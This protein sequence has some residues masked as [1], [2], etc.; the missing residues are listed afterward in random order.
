MYKA[1]LISLRSKSSKWTLNAME[2][3]F[4]SVAD[5]NLK[6]IEINLGEA[7]PQ[8]LLEGKP[9]GKFD[10]V[11][12]KGS[13]RYA[14]ILRS[15]I[16]A[17]E[18]TSYTPIKSPA[19]TTGHDKL[20]TQ[21]ELQ[22]NS[23][24]TPKTYI[25]STIQA[26][27]KLFERVAYPIVI[28]IPKGTQGKGVMFADS[29]AAASSLLDTL[30]ALKQPFLIQEYVENEGKDK[31]AFVVG[32]KVVAAI[33]RSAV[34]EEKRANTH[35][36]AKAKKCDLTKK[37]QRL[38]VQTAKTIG[39][40]IC[41]VDLIETR[42]GPAVLE[43]NLSPG[44]QGITNATNVDVADEIAKFLFEST[45]KMKKL[46]KGPSADEIISQA[47]EETPPEL[48]DV[49]A[50]VEMRG[51]KMSIPPII[52]KAAQLEEGEEVFFTVSKGKIEIKKSIS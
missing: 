52:T 25:S 40:E 23:I 41:G 9:F 34:G 32:N 8:I 27:R 11:Y 2:K 39:A 33:E 19:F 38:A 1:A 30:T 42:K 28:K 20:L 13:Y 36:G 16:A 5:I 44:L 46:Q 14:D 31:R 18:D 4:D 50:L 47:A 7:T 35:A 26:A 10:C 3:Y 49:I 48:K 22:K 45:K 43:L 15:L 6:G 17:I 24:P 51:S 37:E 29:Y 12:V 21:I